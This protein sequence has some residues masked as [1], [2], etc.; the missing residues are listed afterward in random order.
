[1]KRLKIIFSMLIITI[2]SM[3]ISE[4][5][6]AQNGNTLENHLREIL[7]Q[8]YGNSYLSSYMQPFATAFGTATAGALFHRAN[9]KDFLRVDIGINS[10]YIVIPE[11]AKNFMFEG[12]EVPTFFGSFSSAPNAVPGSGLT[13]LHLSQVQLNLGLLANFEILI[14][15]LNIQKIKEVGDMTLF[16]LGMKYDMTDLIPIPIFPIDMSVQALYQTYGINDWLEAGTFAMNIHVS[17]GIVILPVNVYSGIGFEVSA[18]KI[19]TDKI[20]DIGKNGIGE[21]DIDGENNL[22]M[23]FGFSLTLAIF[24]I[25]ADYN[26][27]EYNSLAGG[28]ML[29]F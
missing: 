2:S 4:V 16:G 12:E 15:G 21:V 23:N 6:Y 9:V 22:R 19:Y 14:R 26:L 24:N 25:H 3:C 13:S 8:G 18:L 7:I 11:K 1:M 27:G 29:V 5:T 20:P 10:V 28:I 17:K